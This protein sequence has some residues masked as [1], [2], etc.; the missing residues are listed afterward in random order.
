[1][2]D[3]ETYSFFIDQCYIANGDGYVFRYNLFSG[4]T[5]FITR[6]WQS[7]V[8]IGAFTGILRLAC[9][10][11]NRERNRAQCTLYCQVEM[12]ERKIVRH[13]GDKK[14]VIF[15]HATIDRIHPAPSSQTVLLCP[16]RHFP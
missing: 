8:L 6:F 5:T 9:G 15:S 7:Q 10:E 13:Q 2:V 14:P 1:M 3:Y 16:A 4:D 12:R 11:A